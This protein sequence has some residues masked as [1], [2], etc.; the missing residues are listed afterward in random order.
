MPGLETQGEHPALSGLEG[1]LPH[2][3]RAILHPKVDSLC[4][5]DEKACVHHACKMKNRYIKVQLPKTRQASSVPESKQYKPA[6]DKIQAER[7]QVIFVPSWHLFLP[8]HHG[9]LC[10]T[11]CASFTPLQALCAGCP[12]ACCSSSSSSHGPAKETLQDYAM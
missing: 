5:V 10:E 1:L 6:P 12:L 11:K 2:I 3:H 4:H 9:S 7:N 8:L